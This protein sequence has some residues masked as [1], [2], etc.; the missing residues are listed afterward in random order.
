MKRL[1]ML[2]LTIVL[3]TSCLGVHAFA[4]LP[5]DTVV[6][7]RWDNTAAIDYIFEFESTKIGYAEIGVTGQ[8]GV[9][10]I[11]GD[12]Q[13]YRQ[14]GSSWIWVA[15]DTKTV[16][17]RVLS[18]SVETNGISGQY[19]KAVFTMTVYKNGVGEEIVRTCY[20]WCPTP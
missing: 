10:K 15:G 14:S 8:M 5:A 17:S 18:M 20:D 13:I 9:S 11:E 3:L 19:Y 4:A 6:Q 1:A 7:P 2:V 12:I 16:N